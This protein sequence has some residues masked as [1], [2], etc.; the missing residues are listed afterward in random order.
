MQIEPERRPLRERLNKSIE[1]AHQDQNASLHEAIQTF[2]T[3][4]ELTCSPRSP[5][6]LVRSVQVLALY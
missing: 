3:N 4:I 1:Q 6:F 5:R 2:E